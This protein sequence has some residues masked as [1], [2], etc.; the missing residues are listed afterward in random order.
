MSQHGARKPTYQNQPASS[1]IVFNGELCF[2]V[3]FT[4]SMTGS[5]AIGK[6]RSSRTCPSDSSDVVLPGS[7]TSVDAG[8][9]FAITMR[10][11]GLFR[12]L[13]TIL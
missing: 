1:N 6:W 13:V 5:A 11:C 8:N 3:G 2:F 12:I 4:E 9:S 7:G 10:A